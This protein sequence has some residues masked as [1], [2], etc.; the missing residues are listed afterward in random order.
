M[1]RYKVLLNNG[2]IVVM[3]DLTKTQMLGLK[4][5]N[6]IVSVKRIRKYTIK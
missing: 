3:Y 4:R 2:Y 5:C 1:I 6:G